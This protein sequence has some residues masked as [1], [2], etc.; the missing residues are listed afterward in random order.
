MAEF[1]ILDMCKIMIS[2]IEFHMC[3]ECVFR[4]MTCMQQCVHMCTQH[5]ER[6]TKDIV[7]MCAHG[8]MQH[9]TCTRVRTCKTWCPECHFT[10]VFTADSSLIASLSSTVCSMQSTV[11]AIARIWSSLHSMRTRQLASMTHVQWQNT[12]V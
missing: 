7:V 8:M 3:A 5:S 12:H 6:S 2:D 11:S 4:D 9:V 1:V 10:H